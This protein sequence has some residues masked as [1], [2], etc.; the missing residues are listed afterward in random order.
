M[1]YPFI[2]M[3]QQTASIRL[4]YYKI[5]SVVVECRD[6]NDVCEF[7]SHIINTIPNDGVLIFRH[8]RSFFFALVPGYLHAVNLPLYYRFACQ[9][10]LPC[11][12]Q[13]QH[14]GQRTG[15]KPPARYL[16]R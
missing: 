16:H 5:N 4:A 8:Q 13:A 3:P 12:A 7:K 11:L 10:R 2:A 9:N 6:V 15:E 14:C 1:V